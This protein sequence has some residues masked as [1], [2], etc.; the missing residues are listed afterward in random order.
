MQDEI[1][2][3]KA[4]MM[5]K[6]EKILKKG[7]LIKKE[8]FYQQI[9][10]EGGNLSPFASK[11]IEGSEAGNN[12]LEMR[13]IDK[14]RQET[15]PDRN[16]NAKAESN[17]K[18]IKTGFSKI[19]SVISKRVPQIRADTFTI[20][21][22]SFIVKNNIQNESQTIEPSV[23]YLSLEEVKMKVAE[24][25]K[26]LEHS[27]YDLITKNEISEKKLLE[28]ANSEDDEEQKKIKQNAFLEEKSKNEQIVIQMEQ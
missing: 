13:T 21:K 22:E 23:K 18:Q 25:R 5:D 17:L 16:N 19:V 28:Q 2:R 12:S 26:D 1:K 10:N 11:I 15:S 8:E 9:F 14:E 7:K 4:E 24:K 20:F 6:F 27:L 3:K